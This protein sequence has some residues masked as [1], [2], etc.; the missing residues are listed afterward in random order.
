MRHVRL[1]ELRDTIPTTQVK[2]QNISLYYH[3]SPLGSF[4]LSTP[5]SALKGTIVIAVIIIN[6]LNLGDFYC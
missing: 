2:N 1:I 3:P 5:A 6:L 4:T